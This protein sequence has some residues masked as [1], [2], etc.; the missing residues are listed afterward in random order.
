M[1]LCVNLKGKPLLVFRDAQ[2]CH[3]ALMSGQFLQH[4]AR[5][6][7]PND[8]VLVVGPADESLVLLEADEGDHGGPVPGKLLVESAG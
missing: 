1:N 3:R 4:L 7:V 2:S 8:D 6:D 5:M